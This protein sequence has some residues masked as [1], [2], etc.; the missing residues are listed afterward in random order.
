[1]R[2][3]IDKNTF[4][5]FGM[6]VVLYFLLPFIYSLLW[7]SSYESTFKMTDSYLYVLVVPIVLVLLVVTDHLVPRVKMNLKWLGFL[8]NNNVVP[9]V[10]AVLF[11]ASSFW[12]SR[13]YSL[14][15]KHHG[16]ISDAG[17]F[18]ILLTALKA[19]FRGFLLYLLLSTFS[20]Y[21]VSKIFRLISA[22]V[23]LSFILSLMSSFD[24][25]FIFL[26]FLFAFGMERVLG[27]RSPS[28]SALFVNNFMSL[29]VVPLLLISIIYIGI[30][31]KI[32]HK[33]AQAQL[34]DTNNIMT[35]YKHIAKRSSTLYVS[36]LTSGREFFRDPFYSI[37]A[38]TGTLEN[39]KLR[40]CILMGT[41]CGERPKVWSTNR[42]NYLLLFNE[43]D[44]ERTG[45]TP[46]I[47]A[48]VFY[49]PFFPY[50][51]AFVVLYLLIFLRL[52]ASVISR[53][54]VRMSVLF[55]LLLMLFVIPLFENPISYLNIVDTSG[56]YV[57]S[58]VSA[59]VAIKYHKNS[60]TYD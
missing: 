32:G 43:D 8:Y 36:T 1:M 17:G 15:F 49:V 41:K 19:Y 34:T 35:V 57:L 27:A 46:G 30:A 5:I 26:S 9:V 56:V 23:S 38:I 12:F 21:R 44:R 39:L 50:S 3:S 6:Y 53:V 24:A 10:L 55:K 4:S 48:M 54:R 14:S 40:L 18:S 47:F 37:D 28:R 2:R 60:F 58:F 20:G 7:R 13:T 42:L 22:M 52:I 25:I 31:N 29:I 51:I 45:A 59:I 33:R 11:L 16:V